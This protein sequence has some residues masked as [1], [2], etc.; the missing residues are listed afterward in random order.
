MIFDEL[1][2]EFLLSSLSRALESDNDDVLRQVSTSLDC[3]N[4]RNDNLR[5]A[6]CI[7]H[8]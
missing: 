7:P 1:S 5:F 4:H 8:R 6:G 2:S 3:R